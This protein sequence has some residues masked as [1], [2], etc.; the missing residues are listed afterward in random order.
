MV[1]LTV[2]FF[3]EMVA[4]AITP[5]IIL[6]GG[7]FWTKRQEGMSNSE[8][9][10]TLSVAVLIA[11]PLTSVIHSLS[12][13]GTQLACTERI[14]QYLTNTDDEVVDIREDPATAA[15]ISTQ[16]TKGSGP[17]A[18][19]SPESSGIA[20]IIEVA[21]S[22]VTGGRQI[23]Q[24][25][26][27]TF[28]K[29][30]TTMIV[31]PVGGGKSTLLGLLTGETQTV[32][33]RIIINP[34]EVSHCGQTPWLENTTIRN[35]ILGNLPFNQ[36]KYT[37]VINACCLEEDI[38]AWPLRDEMVAGSGGCNLSG[39]QKQRVVSCILLYPLTL[40]LLKMRK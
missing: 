10:A 2:L 27:V 28:P 31:G 32:R 34:D 18:A 6:A 39:G 25:C 24:D 15:P 35:N 21:T 40:L 20:H 14:Q 3:A 22:P 37:R 13:L 8:I 38:A 11:D 29:D 23:L 7:M 26:N 17:R 19:F 16:P 4:N 36:T 12:F 30:K 33:G 1:S 9:Y 5:I